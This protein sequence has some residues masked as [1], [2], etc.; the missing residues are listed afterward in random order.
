METLPSFVPALPIRSQRIVPLVL[1]AVL[2]ACGNGS[3]PSDS[4]DSSGDGSA[5]GG[6]VGVGGAATTT[7]GS[8]GS[9]GSRTPTGAQLQD[10]LETFTPGTVH[11]AIPHGVPTGY[12]W[13]SKSGNATLVPSNGE[14]VANWWGQI[15][16]D[17]SGVIAPN[18]RVAVQGVTFLALYADS[19]AWVMVQTDPVFGGGAWAEDFHSNCDG[20]AYDVRDEGD[21]SSWVTAPGCNAHYWPNVG[22]SEIDESQLRAVVVVGFTRLVLED[23][24]GQDQ[25]ASAAYI[26]GLGAD[27]RIPGGGCPTPPDSDVVVCN[28]IGGGKFIRVTSEWRTMLMQSMSPD[29][30]KALPLPPLAVFQQPDGLY[31]R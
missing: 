20:T 25:R 14:T 23:P 10:F 1:L 24:K 22:Q 9:G 17:E 2:G 30:L 18:V 26:N 29:E 28:G 11:E 19:D 13:Y 5:S 6:G 27:W 16:V 4:P 12:D 3:G 31:F 7:G 8:S 21:G 15:Y